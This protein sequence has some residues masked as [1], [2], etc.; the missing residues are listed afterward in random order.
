MSVSFIDGH[1]IFW[2][3]AADVRNEE[4]PTS[5]TVPAGPMT[6]AD[7]MQLAAW[8]GAGQTAAGGDALIRRS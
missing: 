8:S 4:Y 5:G 7:Q 3:Y 6:G 1:A 2:T